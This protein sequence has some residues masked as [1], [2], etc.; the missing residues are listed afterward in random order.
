MSGFI[1]GMEKCKGKCVVLPERWGEL[2]VCVYVCASRADLVYV[3]NKRV[4]SS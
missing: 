1:N 2:C 4:W 3:S